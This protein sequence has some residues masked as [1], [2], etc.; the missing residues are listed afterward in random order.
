MTWKNRSNEGLVRAY[1]RFKDLLRLCPHHD[2]PEW[3]LLHIF[4]GGLTE[5]N[6]IEVDS[7]AEGAF[8]NLPIPK[9]WALLNRIRDHRVSWNFGLGSEGGIEIEHDCIHDYNKKG[10]VNELSKKLYLDSDLVLPSC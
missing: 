4:Y 8:I 3:Y 9:A 6:K 5:P 10:H 2:L 1:I 7:F